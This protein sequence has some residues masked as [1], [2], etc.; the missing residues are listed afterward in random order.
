M[1]SQ[2]FNLHKRKETF[3][4]PAVECFEILTVRL[5]EYELGFSILLLYKSLAIHLLLGNVTKILIHILLN[6]TNPV[7]EKNLYDFC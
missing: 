5:M 3:S 4:D 7:F 6:S 2:D 1:I